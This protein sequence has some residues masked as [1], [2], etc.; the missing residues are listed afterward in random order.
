MSASGFTAA[1]PRGRAAPLFT[2]IRRRLFPDIPSIV[3]TAVAA[4]LLA[5]VLPPVI[6][7][8]LIDATFVGNEPA[9]CRSGGACWV[10]VKVHLGQFIYGFYPPPERWRID[11]AMALLMPSIAAVVLLLRRSRLTASFGVLIAYALAGFCLFAGGVAG[12]A[13]VSTDQWGGLVVTGMLAVLG[14]AVSLPV[15]TT[16]AIG[17]RARN[18][19]LRAACSIFVEVFRGVPLIAILFMAVVMVPL[20]VPGGTGASLFLRVAIGICIYASAYMA[21][22]VRGGLRAIAPG[23][24]EAANALGLGRRQTLRLVVLPQALALSLPGIVNTFIALVKDTTL[25]LIIGVFDLLG[26]VQVA[27]TD[28]KWLKVVWEG[29]AFAG[30]VYFVI[31]FTLSQSSQYLERRLRRGHAVAQGRRRA[32]P[33]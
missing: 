13:L 26:I 5:A 21:E 6:R 17:R 1:L 31:C 4:A 32:A 18:P 25:V 28:P 16:L 11:V 20:L 30:A 14:M 27:V 15:G 12:L 3:A 33:A 10:F 8:A 24:S 29:Y 9:D 23:Q 2:W 22:V 19:I 7:W